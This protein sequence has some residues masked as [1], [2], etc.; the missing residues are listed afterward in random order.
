VIFVC[1]QKNI[2]SIDDF[3]RTQSDKNKMYFID[4][5]KYAIDKGA[6]IE[7]HNQY[8]RYRY[9]YKNEYILLF[10]MRP[11]IIVPY[12]NQY[13]RKRDSW[14]S[15]NLFMTEVVKQHDKDELIRY[16]Q[17]K[18]CVCSACSDRKVGPKKNG[19]CCGHWLDIYG[20]KRMAA[21]CHPEIEI[22][23][24]PKESQGSI[25]Y[26]I[27]MSKRMMDIRVMQIDNY[28]F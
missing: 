24:N 15:F 28:V 21:S 27:K 16:I 6:K 23:L 8:R 4:L 9:I 10:E 25:D 20:I 14:V 7:T 19:E 22:S 1:L 5:H 26:D 2:N 13:S 12:N 17:N 18:I 11:S 3:L